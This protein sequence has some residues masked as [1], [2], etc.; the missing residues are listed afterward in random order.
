VQ[1]L[2]KEVQDSSSLL[3]RDLSMSPLSQ[4][5]HGIAFSSCLILIRR[6][7]CLF[8]IWVF[9]DVYVLNVPE[10]DEQPL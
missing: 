8:L 3:Q 10:H 5:G 4:R 6:V 7:L 1:A 2:Q 9:V